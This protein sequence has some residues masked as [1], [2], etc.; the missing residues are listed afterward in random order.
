MIGSD[1]LPHDRHPHPRLW[2]AFAR[3]LG[4]YVRE[5]GLFTLEEAVHKMTGLSAARF[6]LAD[7]GVIRP[8]AYAD[9]VLFDPGRIA[10]GGSFEDPARPAAGI[11]TVLVNGAAVLA[12]GTPTGE[13]PG[14]ALRRAA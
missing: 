3:V 11:E 13:R 4:H 2:G 5:V 10:E 7:R 6:R 9:L 8:G 12:D 14:R 1:G